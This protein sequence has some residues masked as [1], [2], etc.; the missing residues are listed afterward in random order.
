MP[1]SKLFEYKDQSYKLRVVKEWRSSTRYSLGSKFLTVRVPKFYPNHMADYHVEAAKQWAEKQID[2]RIKNGKVPIK[3]RTYEDG[4]IF[5]LRDTNFRIRKVEKDIK[6]FSGKVIQSTLII[7]CPRGRS[8]EHHHISKLVSRV[9]GKYFLPYMTD[10]VDHYNTM[11]FQESINSVRLKNNKSNWGSCSTNHNLNFS[12]RLLFAPEPV[13][14]YVVIH[15]LAHLKEMNHSPRF[16]DIV[17]QVMPDY[18][19]KEK[20]LKENHH[21]CDY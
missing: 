4:Q 13:L 12:T 21:L 15:E 7:E 9:M 6:Q 11:Y 18:K 19:L 10:K 3:I 1:S 14:D 16:W 20:W 17:R 2:R 8:K 5:T